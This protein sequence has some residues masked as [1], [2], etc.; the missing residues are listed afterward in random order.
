M[1]ADHETECASLPEE[2]SKHF[3]FDA[4]DGTAIILN[5]SALDRVLVQSTHDGIIAMLATY[6]REHMRRHRR[7]SFT[8]H[9]FCTGMV[10]KNMTQHRQFMSRMAAMFRDDFPTELFACYVHD[11]PS[12]FAS[13]YDLLRPILPQ[14][15]REKI[16]VV[17]RRKQQST[18][19]TVAHLLNDS[20]AAA[21]TTP[22]A[23]PP[24]II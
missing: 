10:L 20:A 3:C 4:E 22:L 5:Y 1:L 15:A 2:F 6:A 16:I 14:S 13:I 8:Y 23:P 19:A 7:S 21:T 12:F 11:A 24:P 18:A 17:R 9:L